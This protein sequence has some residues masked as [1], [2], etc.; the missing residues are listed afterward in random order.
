MTTV[1]NKYEVILTLIQLNS[2]YPEQEQIMALAT[3][4]E[5]LK[6]YNIKL[7]KSIKTDYKK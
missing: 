2:T 7:S 6:Y 3:V 1:L 4:V 5:K